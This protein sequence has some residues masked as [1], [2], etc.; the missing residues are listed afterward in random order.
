MVGRVSGLAEGGRIGANRF[1]HDTR[2][3]GAISI[4]A[5][6]YAWLIR[7]TLAGSTIGREVLPTKDE[8]Q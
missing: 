5:A 4:K 1:G 2:T 3:V 6:E 8:I 7:A